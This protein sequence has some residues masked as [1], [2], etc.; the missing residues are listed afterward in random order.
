M[1]VLLRAGLEGWWAK[2]SGRGVFVDLIVRMETC[3][4]FGRG[5]TG[6]KG[7]KERVDDGRRNEGGKRP[8]LRVALGGI[9]LVGTGAMGR[10][11]DRA[12]RFLV[13]S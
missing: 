2:R 1:D 3:E 7:I 13:P 9:V 6:I 12:W 11:R 5:A 4:G 10:R 8:Q